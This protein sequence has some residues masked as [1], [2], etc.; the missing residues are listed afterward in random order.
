MIA[1]NIFRLIGDLFTN[2][3]F[4]PFEWIRL[5][6]A[7]ADAGWWISNAANFFFLGVLL[8]LF[9]YW[10]KE[11]KRFIDEGTEDRA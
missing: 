8:V 11:S 6:L 4:L 9:A 1:S 7:K 10:M 5:T 3:L 2:I